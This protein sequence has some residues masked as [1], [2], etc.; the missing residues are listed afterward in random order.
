LIII[1]ENGQIL[2]WEHPKEEK[3]NKDD[4]NYKRKHYKNK[5]RTIRISELYIAKETENKYG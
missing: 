2:F 1:W 5:K 4:M 3:R